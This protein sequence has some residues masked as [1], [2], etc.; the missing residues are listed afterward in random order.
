VPAEPGEAV[1]RAWREALGPDAEVVSLAND[2]VGYVD[3]A[4]QVLAR[5]GEARRTY[6]GP[7]LAQVLGDGL[8][9]AARALP[10]PGAGTPG[11][12]MPAP[13]APAPTTPAATS[14]AAS[15]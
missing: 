2:Y 15:P 10:A 12:A 3:T 7:D 13:S 1:G 14:P 9:A 4:E 5:R 8:R 11:P 6:L